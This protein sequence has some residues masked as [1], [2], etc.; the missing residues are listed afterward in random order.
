MWYE[1]P[2]AA[3]AGLLAGGALSYLFAARVIAKYKASEKAAVDA[4]NRV[5]DKAKL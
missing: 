2:L 4:Y 1:I 3:L 5:L